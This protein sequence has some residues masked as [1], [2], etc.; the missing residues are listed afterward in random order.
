MS[1]WSGSRADQLIA[2]SDC[3]LI[4]ILILLPPPYIRM[5][6]DEQKNLLGRLSPI[7][8]AAVCSG[9]IGLYTSILIRVSL[10]TDTLRAPLSGN[11]RHIPVILVL[12]V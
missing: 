11:H 3:G 2:V 12:R 8:V 5:T 7:T 1:S 10:V 6:V 4:N 9:S